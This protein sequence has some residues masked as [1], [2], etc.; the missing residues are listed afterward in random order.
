MTSGGSFPRSRRLPIWSVS[1]NQAVGIA[2]RTKR[3]LKEANLPETHLLEP[4]FAM[5]LGLLND[6]VRA[7]SNED[8]ALAGELKARDRELDKLHHDV[9]EKDSRAVWRMIPPKA[10]HYLDLVFIARF[11]SASETTRNLGED[12]ILFQHRQRRPPR[13]Q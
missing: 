9:I 5:A 4:L 7:L 12:S 8:T 2:R 13:R 1:P 3:L 6:G 10:Q 11:S